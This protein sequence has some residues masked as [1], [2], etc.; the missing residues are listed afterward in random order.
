MFMWSLGVNA[1][2]VLTWLPHESLHMVQMK[3]Q[4]LCECPSFWGQYFR[5]WIHV[6]IKDPCA[7]GLQETLKVAHL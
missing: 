7:L 5:P 1:G 6:L 3:M 2:I 4:S